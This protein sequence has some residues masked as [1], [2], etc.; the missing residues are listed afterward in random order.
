[1]TELLFKKLNIL[2]DE[3]NTSN[4]NL[5]KEKIL[6]DFKDKK[7]IYL[8]GIIYNKR[9][10]FH[11]NI[12]NIEKNFNKFDD[13]ETTDDILILLDK[14]S[15]RIITGNLSIQYCVSF[16]NKFKEFKE[17]IYKIIDK[18]LK[19]GVN[20]K[21]LNK[22]FENL[23]PEFSVALGNSYNQKYIINEKEWYISRK[24]DGVRC[25]CIIDNFGLIN[26]YSRQG[27]LF[28]T[29]GILEEEIK[30]YNLKNIIFDG[31]II[32]I[33]E[34]GQESFT[35]LMKLIR[36]KDYTISTPKYKVFDI[37]T[38]DEFYNKIGNINFIKRLSRFPIPKNKY[39]SLLEQYKFN[40]FE[41]LLNIS[42]NENWEGLI[43]RKNTFYKGKRTNDILKFKNFQTE[44]YKVIDICIG[45]M[46]ILNKKTNIIEN[47]NILSSVIIKHKD[48]NVN[49]GSGFSIEERMEYYRHPHEI[50]GKTI[51][52]QYFEESFDTKKQKFSL[53]FPIYKG[54]YGITRKF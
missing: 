1:M 9:I 7:I 22:S 48:S 42:K 33:D 10:V 40:E 11:I 50:I 21:T 49:V 8:L 14:L 53:R 3:L 37:L 17:L 24:L 16:I 15:K 41:N 25:I 27:H 54:N 36:K 43:I 2:I 46:Q 28:L 45:T 32:L 30:K 31:E 38:L 51:S 12:S 52:V 34:N 6:K 4:S 26:F 19:I 20:T 29:L 39:I 5:D 35:E 23:I 44:E 47:K 18:D 13:I